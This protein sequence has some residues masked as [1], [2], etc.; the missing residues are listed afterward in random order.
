MA[1]M[2]SRPVHVAKLHRLKQTLA[3][4]ARRV[5]LTP[6]RLAAWPYCCTAAGGVWR[7]SAAA[8]GRCCSTASTWMDNS[9]Q[10]LRISSL[11]RLELPHCDRVDD[12][13]LGQLQATFWAQHGRTLAVYIVYHRH[14]TY[15]T[16][17]HV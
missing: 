17:Q 10:L 1:L 5:R 3:H 15:V 2:I 8:G 7:L 6:S 14:F 11:G 13:A 12:S 16:V 4:T 9:C